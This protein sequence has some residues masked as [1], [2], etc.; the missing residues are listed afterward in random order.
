MKKR[1]FG[2]LIS[3]VVATGAILAACGTDEE[4]EKDT[5]NNSSGSDANTEESGDAFSVAMVTDV[6]G[7][8]DTSIKQ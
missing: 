3:S 4:K 2:L 5:S 7:V 8:D 1:K 6:G